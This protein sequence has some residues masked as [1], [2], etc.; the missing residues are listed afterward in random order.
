MARREQARGHAVAPLLRG[1]IGAQ[2]VAQFGAGHLLLKLGT[3]QAGGQETVL[4]EQ[5]V[6][7]ER[8]VGDANGAFLAQ[9]AR[10][11]PRSALRG[12]DR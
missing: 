10:R 7:V 6:L 11:R 3:R 2:P 5:H 12:W 4:I 8:H 1:V 9:C